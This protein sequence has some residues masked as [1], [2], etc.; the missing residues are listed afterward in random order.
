MFI[1]SGTQL[2]TPWLR[3]GLS[4]EHIGPVTCP[5][6]L[7]QLCACNS[8]PSR[9][10][11]VPISFSVPSEHPSTVFGGQ[12]SNTVFSILD[13]GGGLSVF[14]TAVIQ[15]DHLMLQWAK[16]DVII[17]S[18]PSIF[19]AQSLSNLVEPCPTDSVD[20][21]LV[22]NIPHEVWNEPID[23]AAPSADVLVEVQK[24]IIDSMSGVHDERMRMI[25]AAQ[26]REVKLHQI[27]LYLQKDSLGKII[28]DYRKLLAN[29][30]WLI[31]VFW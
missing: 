18:L 30:S 11:P 6:L 9:F 20:S 15:A 29:S 2:L 3:L 14:S 22:S 4:G 23:R 31:M 24:S 27:K 1:V 5:D 8:L 13:Q 25:G 16:D 21:V 19:V 26:D 17:D 10:R 28:Y 12:V 7:N